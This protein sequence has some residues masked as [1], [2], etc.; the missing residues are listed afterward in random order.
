MDEAAP[1]DD[2]LKILIDQLDG[3][4]EMLDARLGE[5][6]MFQS[7]AGSNQSTLTDD[8]YFWEPVASC[9]SLRRR[10]EGVSGSGS[11]EWV[12][13][14][15]Y[16]APQPPPF[17]TIAWRMCHLARGIWLRYDYTFGTHSRTSDDLAWPTAAD[18]SVA[19]LQQ[20]L[21]NWRN[22]VAQLPS[23]ELDQI[24]RSQF[25]WGLDRQVR[26]I[27]L[28]AWTNLEF[29]HHAAEIACLRDL[30]QHRSR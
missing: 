5:R 8:E 11:G 6:Q 26:F 24:G 14:G 13:E 16:P 3:A 29:A 17:T 15:T 25:P 4:W 28:L 9:W 7:E 2:R 22:A 20:V 12:L 27:D 10:H 18:A 1:S 30:Y 21:R 23:D 19:L